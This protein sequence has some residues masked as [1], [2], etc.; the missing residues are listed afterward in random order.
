MLRLLL[1][2]EAAAEGLRQK[3]RKGFG[4]TVQGAFDALDLNADG[5]ITIDEVK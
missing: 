2:N 4:F 5:Q 3:L 1:D